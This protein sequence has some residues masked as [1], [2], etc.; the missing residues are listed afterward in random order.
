MKASLDKTKKLHHEDRV[1]SGQDVE[2]EV[3][4]TLLFLRQPVIHRGANDTQ[5][6]EPKDHDQQ[7]AKSTVKATSK[8]RKRKAEDDTEN[9]TTKKLAHSSRSPGLREDNRDKTAESE[10]LVESKPVTF[11]ERSAQLIERIQ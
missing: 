9:R 6:T 1:V 7:D 4:H 3:A 8:K 5:E 2:D 10:D 11:P